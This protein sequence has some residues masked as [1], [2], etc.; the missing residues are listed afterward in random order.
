MS[1]KDLELKH[2]Y[3]SE[4]DHILHDFYIPVLTEGM[5][6]K[7]I[8][9]YFSSK[10]FALAACGFSKF[11][12]N[13]GK[14]KFIMNI[15]L[16]DE[17]Y[18]QIDKG[19]TSPEQIIEGHFLEDLDNLEDECIK[20]S[21]K[22][23]GWLISNKYL[24]LKIGYIKDR[25]FGN[26]IL[27]Q[28]TGIVEDFEQNI[29]AFSGSN[30]ESASGWGYNS[31]KFK[32]FFSWLNG[33]EVFVN[34]DVEDFDELW[35]NKGQ[36]TKVIDF[37]E[38]AENKLISI[39]FNE[40]NDIADLIKKVEHDVYPEKTKFIS[41]I[42]EN[43]VRLREYQIEAI[44]EWFSN[45][46]RGIFEMA[47]GTGK[48]YTALS[49]LK[50]LLEREQ[51][52][53][54]I[55]SVPFLHLSEQ[56]KESINNL[57]I[58]IPILYASSAQP[59]WKDKLADKILDNCLGKN[60]QFIVLTTHD[61]FYS[62][63]FTQLIEEVTCPLLLI[64]D[65]VHGMG[66]VN[67]ISGLI[68]NYD[69]RLGLSATPDRYFDELGTTKLLEFF[70]KTVYSF[71]LHRALT[72]INPDNGETY[73][74]PYEYKPIF[75]ELT[76]EE[77]DD[78]AVV[79]KQIAML[80]SKDNRS[81]KEQLLLEQRLR[82]RQDIL[83][84]AERKYG[85]FSDLIQKLNEEKCIDHTLVYC[86][87]A[88]IKEAQEII[89]QKDFIVQHKFTSGEDAVKK[90]LKYG[91]RTER[92]YLLHN[93]DA[94]EYQVLVAIKCL[95]EGV[96]V[97]S[98]KKAILMSS[99]GNPKEY[100]QRRGRVLRRYPGKEKAVIYDITA[101]PNYDEYVINHDTEKSMI[102]SQLKRIVEFAKDA[103]NE[104]EVE[105][106]IFNIKVKYNI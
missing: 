80:F 98:I 75:V 81:R 26:A 72:E 103:L 8:T 84:N 15:Q 71:D 54:V 49:A 16:S 104:D 48:T 100:I 69:Y 99:S 33:N 39:I 5:I 101:L 13:N 34:Q 53:I 11:V 29:I 60:D 56:W 47:T 35:N 2:S 87:P 19:L 76:V 46:C 63:K 43:E 57:Q 7:R 6:Y 23:L 40:D 55:I 14:M 18:E 38:A 96:D 42:S 3:S 68:D 78:Y 66:S 44:D 58:E 65:E 73:L 17:D 67:R 32:V 97:P 20:N 36:K 51:Q 25:Y 106:E 30:N 24:E 77:M 4:K 74:V 1:L 9:G 62:D 22:V 82:E 37:P 52:L 102:E 93:F 45:D 41:P 95:D 90:Q 91:G 79:S 21:A 89:R 64:G 31:E 70:G 94:G 61:S 10:S 85:V 28:K 105:T 27:H 88:Q 12:Q 92:E 59:K 50:K 86:S 83:K